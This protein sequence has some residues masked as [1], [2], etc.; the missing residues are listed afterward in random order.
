MWPEALKGILFCKTLWAAETPSFTPGCSEHRRV[1]H[2]DME[3]G[4]RKATMLRCWKAV[5]LAVLATQGTERP[6]SQG[7]GGGGGSAAQEL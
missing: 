1:A 5:L 2:E 4:H 7:H 3:H 6:G